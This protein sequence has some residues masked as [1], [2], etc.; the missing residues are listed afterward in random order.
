[1]EVLQRPTQPSQVVMPAK[2]VDPNDVF[3][4]FKKG[5]HQSFMVMR[6]HSKLMNG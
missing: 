3:D 4:K 2:V 1:M 5:H 6:T